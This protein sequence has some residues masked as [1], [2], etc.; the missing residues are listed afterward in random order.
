MDD[1]EI[2]AEYRRIAAEM[3]SEH[4]REWILDPANEYSFT[5]Q[6][7]LERRTEK[8][9]GLP[10]NRPNGTITFVLEI[11]GGASDSEG[12]DVVKT[13]GVFVPK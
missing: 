2:A 8:L 10:E 9:S 4:V 12:G 13:P 3:L 11:N 1:E 7:G 5:L 6:R